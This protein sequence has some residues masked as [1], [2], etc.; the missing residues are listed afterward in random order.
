MGDGG[1]GEFRRTDDDPAAAG[2]GVLQADAL[3]DLGIVDA[4]AVEALSAGEE[5][6]PHLE[7]GRCRSRSG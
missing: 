7:G 5:F 2:V 1:G 6:V 3:E 4:D